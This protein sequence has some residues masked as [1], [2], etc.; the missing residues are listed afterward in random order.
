MTEAVDTAVI[1]AAGLGTRLGDLG[2][3]APKGFLQFGDRPIVEESVERLMTA[4]I[5]RVVIVTGFM[6]ERYDDLAKRYK[7]VIRTIY[8]ELYAES[9]TMYSL[10]MAY[11]A[12]ESRFIW[13]ESDIIYE[14]RALDVILQ[15]PYD[16]TILVSGFTGA[17]DEVFVETCKDKLTA[18][19]KNREELGSDIAGELVGIGVMSLSFYST[20]VEHAESLFQDSLTGHYE[21]ALVDV[22]QTKTVHCEVVPDLLWAEIDDENHLKRAKRLYSQILAKRRTK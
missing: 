13:L 14:Q 16:D 3:V 2:K 17:G 6:K 19:S 7:G 4:G 10:S 21:P 20:L 8:N 1:L 5:G 15:S 22:A 11:Q 18:M 9:G 12:V